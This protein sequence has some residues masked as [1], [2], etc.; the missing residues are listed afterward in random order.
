MR[1][2]IVQKGDTLWK[3]SQKYGVNFE[4]LKAANSHLSN[5]D[6]IMPGMKIKIPT[7]GVQAKKEAVIKEQPKEMPIKEAPVK[8]KAPPPSL[9]EEKEGPVAM[10]SPPPMPQPSY[11]MQNMNFNF[12]KQKTQ[13]TKVTAPPKMPAAKEPPK[14]KEKPQVM[15]APKKPAPVKAPAKQM[16]AKVPVKP[17]VKQ[18]PAKQ[19]P[20]MA[21]CY[22]VTP[23]MM[24]GCS[25][26]PPAVPY[27][28]PSAMGHGHMPAQ[29]GFAGQPPMHQG[30]PAGMMPVPQGHSMYPHGAGMPQQHMQG[31]PMNDDDFDMADGQMTSGEFPPS[32]PMGQAF[33]DL[34]P[35]YQMPPSFHQQGQ[36]MMHMPS[37][38]QGQPMMPFQPQMQQMPGQYPMQQM[39]GQIP[40][41][42]QA[43]GQFPMQAHGQQMPQFQTPGM[44][45]TTFQ[46]G[47]NTGQMAQPFSWRDEDEDGDE[48]I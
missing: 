7:G 38:Q 36:P 32:H 27:N 44:Y 29:Q 4:D 10:P 30:Y 26:C 31:M 33:G 8:P 15:P 18:P 5:P 16:P 14:L 20:H 13:T 43:Q 11:H 35:Q 24:S 21:D 34:T 37:H 1:I 41:Q 23:V 19:M 2:H 25:P 40:M 22:P 48:D 28:W 9:P 45:P 42:P 3:L 47:Y 17:M 12:Y 46:H 6:L 39:P